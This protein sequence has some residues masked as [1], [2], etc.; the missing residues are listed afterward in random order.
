MIIW[1]DKSQPAMRR[2]VRGHTVV[3]VNVRSLGP[4]KPEGRTM[5]ALEAYCS[6]CRHSWSED[7]S[8]STR[9]RIL[10]GPNQRGVVAEVVSKAVSRTPSCE[11]IYR[12][13]VA[14]DVMES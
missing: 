6:V 4:K 2:P 10:H 11:D 7:I 1:K 14:R 13:L 12:A 9:N 8:L 3:F 5:C